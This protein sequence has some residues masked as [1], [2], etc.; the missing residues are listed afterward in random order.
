MKDSYKAWLNRIREKDAAG[1]DG[2]FWISV[3]EWMEYFLIE[4]ERI[5]KQGIS[6]R[7]FRNFMRRLTSKKYMPDYEIAHMLA[8]EAMMAFLVFQGYGKAIRIYDD[9]GKDYSY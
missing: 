1:S 2:K 8:D 3:G 5:E 6:P 9:M 4:I 7:E